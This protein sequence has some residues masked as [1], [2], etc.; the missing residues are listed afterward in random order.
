MMKTLKTLAILL[1]SVTLTGLFTGCSDDDDAPAV[2]Y[3]WFAGKW[4]IQQ[5]GVYYIDNSDEKHYHDVRWNVLLNA[6][7]T[8]SDG[9]F[10]KWS[11]KG[12][13]FDFG[14]YEDGQW[15]DRYTGVFSKIDEDHFKV[16][17]D[18]TERDDI[19]DIGEW[20]NYHYVG[21]LIFTR[22]K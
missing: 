10:L 4:Q 7:G 11:L 21:D 6:D 18:Y 20:H 13:T 9:D 8:G 2:S 14:C 16:H 12:S 3:E 1:V 17:Y 5:I 22:V 19:Y 15:Y